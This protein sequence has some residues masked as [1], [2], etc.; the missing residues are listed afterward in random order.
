MKFFTLLF[1]V[2]FAITSCSQNENKNV[3]REETTEPIVQEKV[4]VVLLNID[5]LVLEINKTR[6]AIES[7]LPEPILITNQN[8]RAKTKQKWQKI[9]F[10]VIDNQLSRIKTYPH[11]SVSKRTEE[12]YLKDG[13]LILAVIEDDGSGERGKLEEQIDKMY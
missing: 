9:H 1:V 6:A 10:Y 11:E 5:S 13:E 8:F 7:N 2:S 4:E 12:F 3:E